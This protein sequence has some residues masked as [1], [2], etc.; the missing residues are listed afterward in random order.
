MESLLLEIGS[1]E[2]PAGYIVPA[3][4][5]L[6]RALD[7]KLEA[8]R[9]A[10]SK[11]RTYGTPRRLAIILDE[12]ADRQESVVTEMIGPPKSVAFDDAGKPKVPAVKFAEKAGVAVEELTFQETEKGVYLCA[13]KQDEGRDTLSILQEL[14]PE[15]ISHIP[16][17]KS[18]RW[19]ALTGTFARPVFSLVALLGNEII[20]FAWNGVTSGRQTRGHFFMAPDPIDIQAPGDYVAALVKA[21][22][23]VD[24]PTRRKMVK[25]GVEAAA[26]SLGGEA[27]ED[28]ELVDIVTN[29]LEYPAPVG[30]RFETGFLEV[31][32]KVLITAMREHQKYF[33]IQDNEG[34]L[35]PC[36]V[37]VNNT[38]CK[39][40]QL[41][42]TGHERVLRARLSDAKFF[43][44]VDKKQSMEDWV[45]RLE[46]ILF[47]KKLGTVREKVARVEE[48]A[49]FLAGTPEIG[50]DPEKALQAAHFSKADLV[51]GLVVEFTK[52]QGVMGKAYANL[53]GLDK[54][55]ASAVEEHYLPAYSGGPLPQTKTGDAVAIADKMDSLCGCFAV[56]LIPSGNRDPYAL[57]RQAIG[58]IRIFQEKGYALSLG[59]VVDKGLELV[60]DKATEDLSETRE[61][62][63]SFMADRL[64]HMLAEQGFSKDVIQA[65][66]AISCDDIPYLW[67]RVAAVEKL[68][69]LPDY[70]ALAQTFKRV[71][72]IIKQAAEK[73]ALPEKN[74]DPSLFEKDCEQA[75]L[76]AF[77]ATEEKING[78]GV[79]EALLEIAKLRPAVDVFF[80][81][82][83]VMAEDEKVRENRL[84]LLAGIA[85]LFGRFADFSRIST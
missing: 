4:E 32:D 62:V 50:G 45:T 43:F 58:V 52:L 20:P 27:I 42:A 76:D 78:L 49:R 7:T 35:M 73:G 69:T 5:A 75:L 18:M 67:Q 11:P 54:E 46:G 72:N 84:A 15:I 53:A 64:A 41:V 22:V 65:A 61:K 36:F 25:E 85:G 57:R 21:K 3:L 68:K 6:A 16:F 28:E 82:V 70:E 74:V 56:G 38:Q 10:H 13:K 59:A 63:I 55:V 29:L 83:M 77:K 39:D 23:I 30:G 66:I 24:I 79:D 40:P 37:A 80:V 14:L 17:P 1:E 8:A 2:I 71:A 12:V 60:K 9:I 48:M 81:D 44:D 47:Q 26:K 31:P 33:A 51:S 34:K 19:A